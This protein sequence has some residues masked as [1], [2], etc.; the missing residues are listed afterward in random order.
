MDTK[1]FQNIH[2]IAI[3]GLSPNQQ[4]DSFKVANFLIQKDF[5]VIPIY[6]KEDVILG[7]KVFRSYTQAHNNHK[8]D[9]VVIFRKSEKCFEIAQEIITQTPLPK[10]VW[11]QLG[12]T[13]IYAKKILEDKNIIFIEDRCI[14]I[15][16]QKMESLDAI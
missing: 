7:K 14:K 9:C 2:T 1:I 11:L 4:K 5:E 6:P 12:I 13:N 8:I 16:L 10:I 3:I 15:E